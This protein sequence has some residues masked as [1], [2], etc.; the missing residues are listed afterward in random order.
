MFEVKLI[1]HS[2]CAYTQKEILTWELSYQRFIH[3]EVMTHKMLSKNAASSRA[4]PVASVIDMVKNNP[5]MPIHW[6]VNQPGM[7]ADEVF[8]EDEVEIVK[9]L[10][11]TAAKNSAAVAELMTDMK[12]HKQV[13]NR[14]MEPF[15][16]M[17]TVMTGTEWANFF[18]LRNHPDAQPEF[19]ELAQVMWNIYQ[20]SVPVMLLPGDWHLP[21]F[22]EMGAWFASNHNGG[23]SL[24]DAIAISMSCCAQVSYRKTDDTL[25]KAKRVVDRLNLGVDNTKPVHASPSEHQATPMEQGEVDPYDLSKGKNLMPFADT[26]QDGITAWHKELGFMSGNLAGYIQYRQLIPG[27]TRW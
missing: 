17:K 2:I 26:W 19:R 14:I 16:W 10:W 9:G 6:G 24:E 15:Q 20:S 8:D 11:L 23:Y 5:A 18:W 3:A 27:N 1:A 7:Q 12:V 22:G 25:E 21:Y 13:A 4:I